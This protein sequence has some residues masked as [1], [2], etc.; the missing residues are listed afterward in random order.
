MIFNV[1]VGWDRCHCLA[2]KSCPTLCSPMDYNRPGS[3]LHGIFQVRILEWVAV[4]FTRD[5]SRPRVQTH[6]SSLAGGSFTTEPPG[7]SRWG[8]GMEQLMKLQVFMS[9]G[10]L[11]KTVF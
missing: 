5:L 3:S 8:Q 7:K 1:A 4:S 10:Y 11:D 9:Y 2:A 6:I